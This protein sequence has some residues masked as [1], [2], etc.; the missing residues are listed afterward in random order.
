LQKKKLADS[1]NGLQQFS[2]FVILE[3]CRRLEEQ[4]ME[5]T[6]VEA[7]VKAM[8][9]LLGS[10]GSGGTGGSGGS[11]VSRGMGGRGE[12]GPSV[13]FIHEAGRELLECRRLMRGVYVWTAYNYS[14]MAGQGHPI[15][16]ES[17]HRSKLEEEELRRLNGML[18]EGEQ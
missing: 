11:G 17:E 9:H 14:D 16:T 4:V 1:V 8:Q 10:G 12:G 6:V 15:Y 7:R 3:E 18:F 5:P 2:S 13:E